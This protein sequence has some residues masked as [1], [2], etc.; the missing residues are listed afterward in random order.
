MGIFDNILGNDDD[1]KKDKDEGRLT[2]HKEELDINKSRVQKGEVELSK[3]IVEEQ[4][5]VDVPVTHEEV[6]IERRSI[7]NEASDTPISDEETIRIPVSEE[8]INVDKH[9]VITGEVSAHKREVEETEHVDE[10]LKRE[11]ARINT[12]GDAEIID[13]NSDDGFH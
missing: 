3:E 6:V 8:K 10:K 1:K 12:N 11:E 13:K 9:T 5:T 7:D 4:K 2:L